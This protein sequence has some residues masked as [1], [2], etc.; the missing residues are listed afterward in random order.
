MCL[1]ACCCACM[2][3]GSHW[4]GKGAPCTIPNTH[5]CVSVRCV[6]IDLRMGGLDHACACCARTPTDPRTFSPHT[7]SG[8]R[9]MAS[10]SLVRS[11][12]RIPVPA[13]PAQGGWCTRRPIVPAGDTRRWACPGRHAA[14]HARGRRSSGPGAVPARVEPRASETPRTRETCAAGR[15]QPVR[16]CSIVGQQRKTLLFAGP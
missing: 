12:L 4:K 7:P 2:R 9:S 3:G 16:I 5:A 6:C 1:C 14:C 15:R 8:L 10:R 11:F 13:A